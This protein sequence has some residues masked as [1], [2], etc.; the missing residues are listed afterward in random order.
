MKLVSWSVE[1]GSGP[2]AG[3]VVTPV[4]E[5][6]VSRMPAGQSH[7]YNPEHRTASTSPTRVGSL[8]APRRPNPKINGFAGCTRAHLPQTPPGS[9][10]AVASVMDDETK[11]RSAPASPQE[12]HASD[13]TSAAVESVLQRAAE[14]AQQHTTK[15]RYGPKD[16]YN[17]SV[18][19]LILTV[20]AFCAGLAISIHSSSS[21]ALGLSLIHI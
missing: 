7:A 8:R 10:K 2:R 9:P 17:V 20:C 19:S 13:D 14:Q 12:G 3:F 11:E 6:R 21:A 4:L 1:P 15:K 18:A 5:Q 16:A